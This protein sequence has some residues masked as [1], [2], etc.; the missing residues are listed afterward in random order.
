MDSTIIA[1]II[2]AVATLFAALIGV[3]FLRGKKKRFL[4]DSVKKAQSFKLGFNLSFVQ[5]AVNM[6]EKGVVLPS[7]DEMYE[8]ELLRCRTI[9]SSIGIRQPPHITPERVVD[10][11]QILFEA[12]SLEIRECFRL[13]LIIGMTYFAAVNHMSALGSLKKPIDPEML[14]IPKDTINKINKEKMHKKCNINRKMIMEIDA[15]WDK[16]TNSAKSGTANPSEDEK[17]MR[18]LIESICRQIENA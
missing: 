2:G 11:M 3:S 6:Q 12:F 14:L 7:Q 10:E 9:A 4:T 17:A 5:Y 1:A 15:F 16:A 18:D 13:G 8:K